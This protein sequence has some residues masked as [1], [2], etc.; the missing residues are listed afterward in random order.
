MPSPQTTDVLAARV[1]GTRRA[2]YEFAVIVTEA[3]GLEVRVRFH[4]SDTRHQWRCDSC[5][6]HRFSTC[7]HERAAAAAIRNRAP[8]QR[9]ATH[10]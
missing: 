3:V 8:S 6:A 10:A 7:P 9:N 2:S 4:R 5:G 1:V